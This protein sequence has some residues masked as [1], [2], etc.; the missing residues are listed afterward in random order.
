MSEANSTADRPKPSTRPKNRRTKAVARARTIEDYQAE[1]ESESTLGWLFFDIHRLFSRDFDGRVRDLGLTRSQWR[2]L[3]AVHRAQGG[4]S[5]TELADLTE[6]EKAPLGKILDRLE[7]GGWIIRKNHPTDRRARLVYATAKID[8]Y[9][10]RL[11]Q[12]AKGTFAQMLQ[13]VRQN[14]V[15]ELIARLEKLKRNLGGADD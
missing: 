7:D 8:K 9:A 5:Q 2:V 14:E 13:G 1:L 6:V 4:M 11:A 15:R 12:A 10:D 3:F